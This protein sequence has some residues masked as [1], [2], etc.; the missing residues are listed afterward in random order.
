MNRRWALI[1][2]E[3]GIIFA[4]V[5][6]FFIFGP[7]V[8]QPEG[9]YFYIH[10]GDDYNKVKTELV[11]QKIIPFGLYFELMSIAGKYKNRIRTGRY[12]IENKSSV[13]SLFRKLRSG[14]QDDVRL[15]INKLRTR[16]DLAGKLGEKFEADSAEIIRFLN[17]ND[18]LKKMNLDT[19]TVMSIIIPN[20]YRYHWNTPYPG[21]LRSLQYQSRMFWNTSRRKK[22]KAIGLDSI[23]T[24]IL[25][26]IVEEETNKNDE[27]GLI[28]SVYLNRLSAGMPLQADPT[29]RFALGDFAI[30]R[31]MYGH[32]AIE[33][34]YNTYKNKGLPPGPVCT[35][36]IA[37]IDS[38]LNAPKTDYLY[39][40]ARSDFKGYHAFSVTYDEHLKNARSYQKALDSLLAANK[41]S[42][43]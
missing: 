23:Q 34:P 13:F 18:S 35:P 19:N 21:I 14:N 24:Y 20:T 4:A 39:F 16:Y 31:I 8:K 3:I 30:K 7:V 28:A 27:K 9:K 42:N 5:S 25:A 22:L 38:V 37:S 36:S 40:A 26:S 33:S 2:L 1:I 41:N 11:K 29:V 10:T 43:P 12:L 17:S 32:L 15:V 6:T